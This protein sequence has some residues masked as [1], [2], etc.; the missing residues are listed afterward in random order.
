MLTGNPPY[1]A[2]NIP[3]LYKNI[4]KGNLTYPED[5]SPNARDLLEVK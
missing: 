4:A 3:T 2:D 1:Y 5:V